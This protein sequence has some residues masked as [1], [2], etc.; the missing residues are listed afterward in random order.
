MTIY[1][2]STV[3]NCVQPK[4]LVVSKEIYVLE[5]EKQTTQNSLFIYYLKFLIH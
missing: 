3:E 2:Q 4:S 1:F 5:I